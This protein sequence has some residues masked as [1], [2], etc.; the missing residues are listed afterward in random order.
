MIGIIF[1]SFPIFLQARATKITNKSHRVVYTSVSN[2]SGDSGSASILKS[3]DVVAL[4][5]EGL[6][7]LKETIRLNDN[8]SSRDERLSRVEHSIDSAIASVSQGCIGLLASGFP[9]L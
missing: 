4:H 2:A 1:S 3:G 8:H 7:H 5:Q 6:N 9:S